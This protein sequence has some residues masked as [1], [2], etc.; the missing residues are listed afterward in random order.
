[1]AGGLDERLDG[2]LGCGGRSLAEQRIPA[3]ASIAF[4]A[5]RVEDPQIRPPARRPETVPGDG[6]LHPLADDIATEPDPRPPGDLQAEAGHLGEGS[7]QA[8]RQP[9]RLEDDEE[10]IG[11]PGDRREP[12]E[13]VG[14]TRTPGATSS[15]RAG[16]GRE[17]R[18]RSGIDGEI[19]HE[20]VH[21]PTLDER[22][23]HRQTLVERVGGEHHQPFEPDAPGHGLHRIEAAREVEPGGDRAGRLGLRHEP[24][25]EGRLAARMVAAERDA[26]L[27]GD[28]AD[29]QDRIER[30]E[31]G[32]DDPAVNSWRDVGE[33]RHLGR[34]GHRG[35]RP[36]HL[37]HRPRSCRSPASLKGRQG[38]RDIGGSVGHR[39]R[40]IEHLFYPS[41]SPGRSAA[42]S[43]TADPGRRQGAVLHSRPGRPC[44]PRIP[45]IRRVGM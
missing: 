43:S 32:R 5:V 12:A 17:L 6:H 33:C 40:M 9:R 10:H 7:H 26:S 1:M 8:A 20:E 15:R 30:G 36:D 27:T 19:G 37:P 42:T 18:G 34:Q 45:R 23:C 35:Q 3:E 21:G 39:P 29:A 13:P 14:E 44:R 31:P 16:S 4:A 38:R 24:H 28:A 25:G 22:T 2:G 11:P 41:R